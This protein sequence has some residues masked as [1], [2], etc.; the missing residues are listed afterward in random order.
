M[1]LSIFRFSDEILD[2]FAKHDS[3]SEFLNTD[4]IIPIGDAI[5][6]LNRSYT[7]GP[8]IE[9]P[10]MPC[11]NGVF[12]SRNCYSTTLWRELRNYKLELSSTDGDN[13]LFDI[14]ASE[15]AITIVDGNSTVFHGNCDAGRCMF[16][17]AIMISGNRV[18]ME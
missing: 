3:D 5:E 12:F 14:T 4:G 17:S 18:T 8:L 6:L 1:G 2:N 10:N 15:G 11:Y 13:D 7:D 9:S 16:E